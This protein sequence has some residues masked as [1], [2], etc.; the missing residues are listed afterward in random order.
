[1]LWYKKTVMDRRNSGTP[2]FISVVIPAYNEEAVLEA[3]L[4][5]LSSQ[6]YAGP[7]EVIVV[8][9]ASTDGTAAVA[10]RWGA[11]VVYEPR[12]GI[13][14]ARQTG[15]A[16]ARGAI[17]AGTDADTIVPSHW[18]S[19]IARRFQ[20]H[21]G[22]TVAAGY[23]RLR[24]GPMLARAFTRVGDA[25]SPV[26]ARCLPWAWNFCG[27]NYAVRASAFR[28]VGGFNTALLYGEDVDLCLRLRRL[29]KVVYASEMRVTTSGRGYMRN[30]WRSTGV[31]CTDYLWRILAYPFNLDR[32]PRRGDLLRLGGLLVA[33]ASVLTASLWASGSTPVVR[34]G[35]LLTS[36]AS[37]P[38]ADGPLGRELLRLWEA[39][40]ARISTLNPLVERF[41][42][43]Q[44]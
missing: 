26:I 31:Y 30:L 21:A 1:M 33:G 42:K 6:D 20:E 5:A 8:D 37:S 13:A 12:R 43:R 17:L 34:G 44:G 19:A 41:S 11:R 23:F 15:C 22:A 32:A 24:D 10:R 27:N 40:Q 25:L 39:Y 7:Y 9:N 16:V 14:R 35:P 29:G 38:A 3:C 36:S 4:R 18:L 2:F 28:A